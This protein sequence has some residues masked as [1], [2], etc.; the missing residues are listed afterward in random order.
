MTPVIPLRPTGLYALFVACLLGACATAPVGPQP[1][2]IVYG[3]DICDEC[4][5][6]IS[7]AKF[8]AA[9]LVE[10]G[11]LHKFD[12]IADMLAYHM[13]RPNESVK[14]WFVHDFKSGAWIRAETAFFVVDDR[15]HSP[16][17][18]GLAAFELQSDAK[19][20]AASIGADNIADFD[21][22]RAAVHL[23]LHGWHTTTA[24][25]VSLS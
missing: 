9:T 13:E 17:P 12:S 20:F 15:I 3:Q 10:N 2:D 6:I 23:A 19:T 21:E 1:P 8:A 25:K 14:A 4:G 22:A 24:G 11:A 16:M 7:D 18:P 5:M